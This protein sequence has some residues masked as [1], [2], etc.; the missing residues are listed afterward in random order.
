M[1]RLDRNTLMFVDT[2]MGKHCNIL[3][4]DNLP[5]SN[6]ARELAAAQNRIHSL[7]LEIPAAGVFSEGWQLASQ[8]ENEWIATNRGQAVSLARKPD[9][10]PFFTPQRLLGVNTP[11]RLSFDGAPPE[12]VDYEYDFDLL[13]ESGRTDL[14][15]SIYG[16]YAVV[17]IFD[18]DTPLTVPAFLMEEGKVFVRGEA[19][20]TLL[21]WAKYNL[22]KLENALVKV[23]ETP[24]AVDSARRL[25]YLQPV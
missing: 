17:H 3:L 7:K 2:S 18:E 20:P 1:S 13:G 6:E 9:L 24:P 14:Y 10:R 22:E 19:D 12:V 21:N 25:H 15:F 23:I 5:F 11:F 8:G 4:E 16:G